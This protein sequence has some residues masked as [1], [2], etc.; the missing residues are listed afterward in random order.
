MG[1]GSGLA[2]ACGEDQ[3]LPQ[4]PMWSPNQSANG[5]WGCSE[6]FHL[7]GRQRCSWQC[8]ADPRPLLH[9][10][11]GGHWPQLLPCRTPDGH[12][13]EWDGSPSGGT[14]RAV[15]WFIPLADATFESLEGER[16]QLRL[17]GMQPRPGVEEGSR[18]SLR[19]ALQP[20][21]VITPCLCR[22]H[23]GTAERRHVP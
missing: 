13:K 9:L 2:L 17:Q 8:Q 22:A 21:L 20:P 4:R 19:T 11:S 14:P 1:E 6:P 12:A 18:R 7:P 15:A 16:R 5:D 10:G 23:R 3:S